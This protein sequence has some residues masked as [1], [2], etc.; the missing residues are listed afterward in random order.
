MGVTAPSAVGATAN[1]AMGATAPSAVSGTTAT[2]AVMR[3]AFGGA[4]RAKR[5]LLTGHT[6]FKGSWATAWLHGLGAEVFGFALAPDT[7]PAMF[8]L[9][10][11]AARCDHLL[12]D[13]REEA[14]LAARIEAVDPHIIIHMAAQPLVRLSYAEPVA[15]IAT[16][17]MGTAHLL[18]AVRRRGKPCAVVVV[19]S[20]KCYDNQEWVWGYRETDP[21]G[22]KD[23]Y[24]M[25]KGAAE[26]VTHSFRQSY[27]D[28]PDSPVLVASAR[29]GNVIGGGDWSAD[30][31][32]TDCIAA[33]SAGRPIG[34][35]NP[36]AT[37][38]WQHVLEPLSGYLWLGAKLMAG[39]RAATGAWNF[40]PDVTSIMP[41][42]V[43]ADTVVAAWGEGTWQDM[44]DPAAPKEA[45]SLGLSCEKAFHGL[46]WRPV[47]GFA[48]AVGTTVDWYKAHQ[49]GPESGP[50]A[51]AQA[52]GMA[53]EMA[54]PRPDL[55]A[56]TLAQIE[57][58]NQAAQAIGQPWT[59][60]GA[61]TE[62]ETGPETVANR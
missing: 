42:R 38:P 24:S 8:D 53:G 37:R 32:V 4:Y 39:E 52:G 25:S 3:N 41:V 19:T 1:D 48:E 46:G 36:R 45:M 15:T 28:G 33:L 31:I 16:N 23:P 22:G 13:V 35:R 58:Y 60:S 47:Y 12:A 51:A 43:L 50:E 61:Q 14:A 30:R 11:L 20:D 10:G 34:V 62:P 56:L 7:A 26:L 40:G 17:V 18:E 6:G 9:L 21:L 57:A 59:Q 29:A 55:L 27:F 49:N 54:V 5:V 44:S 2:D